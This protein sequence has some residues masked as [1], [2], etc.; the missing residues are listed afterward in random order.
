MIDA[1][2]VLL[3]T[4][5]HGA[6]NIRGIRF[7][8]LY[9]LLRSFELY[10]EDAHLDWM[11]LEG[12]EDVDLVGIHFESEY[13]QVKT[14]V[15]PWSWAKLREPLS[16]FLAAHRA[17]PNAKLTL[18]V[19]F[20][21]RHEIAALVGFESLPPH[22][23]DRIA[24]KFR[25]LMREIGASP[26][27]EDSLRSR[28]AVVSIRDE[29]LW[30][31]LSSATADAFS[32]GTSAV[33]TYV[34]ALTAR[35]LE[36]ASE[37]KLLTRSDLE[38]VRIAIGEA[39]SRE[40]EFQAIGR[41]LISRISWAPDESPEDFFG[42]KG[43][44]P[45][46][47]VDGLDVDRP[48][49]IQLIDKAVKSA[50]VCVL[51]TASGQGKSALLYRYAHDFW[52][53][54]NVLVLNVA[55]SVEQVQTIRSYLELL[56]QLGQPILVLIDNAGIRTRFWSDIAA[57]CV[58]LGFR[59]LVSV[60]E[61]DWF[62]FAR[63][64]VTSYEVLEPSLDLA[65]ARGIFTQLRSAGRVHED[66]TSAERAYDRIGEPHLL[67]EYVYLLTY[68]RMLEERLREQEQRFA[69]QGEDPVKTEVLRRVALGHV[70]GA[71]VDA[72]R[73]MSQVEPREDAG[74]IL[75]SLTGEYIRIAEDGIGGLHWVRSD[76]LVRI[77]HETFPTETRTAIA[78]LP[79][80]NRSDLA[81]Y[82]ANALTRSA[83]DS[84]AFIQGTAHQVGNLD[85][86]DY[87][88]IVDGVFEAGERQFFRKNQAL[89]DE[90]Y[91]A[92]GGNLVFLVSSCVLPFGKPVALDTVIRILGD[93]GARLKDFQDRLLANSEAPRGL[94]AAREFLNSTLSS[95]QNQTLLLHPGDIGRLLD[96][97][98]LTATAF[99]N[100]TD[101]RADLTTR[102]VG[103][104]GNV[105]EIVAFAQ[106]LFRYDEPA[107]REWLARQASLLI[108]YLRLML[109]CLD[110]D[111]SDE[112]VEVTFLYDERS[113]IA[114]NDQAISRLKSL[115]SAFPF[116][117]RYRSRGI[118][119][120]PSGLSPSVDSTIKD[121]PRENLHFQSDIAK[122]VI[123]GKSVDIQYAIDCFYDY[124]RAWHDFR[125]QTLLAV[126]WIS[127]SLRWLRT[128]RESFSVIGDRGKLQ[129]F[130]KIEE[131]S[132]YLPPPPDQAPENLKEVL[133]LS[134]L[135][136]QV[137]STPSSSK[138]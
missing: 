133:K 33:D 82:V 136:G 9:S 107:Y 138:R 109:D 66:I 76:H 11:R 48:N 85:L 137:R 104:L 6:I 77:L 3:S 120:L 56:A 32:L 19:N 72:D 63:E 95:L 135:S 30:N 81:G 1:L 127:Q 108:D 47:I 34:L 90:I 98:A 101:L 88:A 125:Q 80:I 20:P 53:S 43:T 79:A 13:V 75:K 103:T 31:Q 10:D 65:E 89:F 60:R 37:R 105:E 12:I 92:G 4:R 68:G 38:A 74:S 87:L 132:K 59:V 45:G 91:N 35:F 118:W 25:N 84:T 27:E 130:T 119:L 96:W 58:R 93:R 124:Q 126:R 61:E 86:S 52:P 28:L 129:L 71:R 97:C 54:N 110:I 113:K 21:L 64:T 24:R 41:G 114:P 134:P 39:L 57:D 121:M 102:D 94:H 70:L 40:S 2:E 29:A 112:A 18:A 115:R 69:E 117:D 8:L 17:N 46:H 36:W 14:S 131:D 44:R 15:K 122:N 67:L 42:G 106:G 73:L 123:W 55:E 23:Q 26:G 16:G 78:T 49:W 128:P 99:P 7:Q 116:A 62:R 111:V 50:K 22:E 5:F 83:I 51:R 100:W